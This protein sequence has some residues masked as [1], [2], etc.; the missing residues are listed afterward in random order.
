MRAG[1]ARVV[2]EQHVAA[3]PRQ[4]LASWLGLDVEDTIGWMKG[5]VDG[6]RTNLAPTISIEG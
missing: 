6:D 2:D 3:L 5:Q 4:E 1:Y